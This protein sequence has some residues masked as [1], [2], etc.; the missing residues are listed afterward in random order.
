MET[1]KDLNSVENWIRKGIERDERYTPEDVLKGI[2]S[3]EFQLFLYP[4]GLVVTQITGHNRL[5]VFLLSG[6]NLENWKHK[7]TQDLKAYADSLGIKI[8]E[9][10][11]RPGLEK[12]LQDCGW[13]KEQVVL[14]L[15]EK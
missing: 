15:R 1:G 14:R 2:A 11:C 4:E 10:Y 8:L 5:L 12:V 7:A 3:G 9:A 6:E 13:K